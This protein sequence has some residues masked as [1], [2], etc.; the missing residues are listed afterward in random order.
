MSVIYVND[1]TWEDMAEGAEF[2]HWPDDESLPGK[3]YRL[4]IF[5]KNMDFTQHEVLQV[6]GRQV[7][8]GPAIPYR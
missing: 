4:T 3:G 7:T 1:R 5:D 2:K 8:V 6:S